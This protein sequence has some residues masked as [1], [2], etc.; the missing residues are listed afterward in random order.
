M[1]SSC[2]V[3]AAVL[4]DAPALAELHRRC[5]RETYGQLLSRDFFRRQS[6]DERRAMWSA[7]LSGPD[8]GRHFVAEA[9]GV[10]VGFAGSTAADG[11]AE[12]WGIYLLREHHGSGLGQQLLDAT[13]GSGP[14]RLWVAEENPRAQAFYRKN[15]FA[16]DGARE[17]VEDWEGLV[18]CR[19]VR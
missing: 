2:R 4:E 5:W 19:M 16:F 11:V 18:E 10:L 14:A 3:R 6:K 1:D 12:L 9:D 15:G 13:L 17:A 7:L 8:A